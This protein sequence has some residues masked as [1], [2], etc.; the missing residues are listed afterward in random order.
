MAILLAFCSFKNVRL[1]VSKRPAGKTGGAFLLAAAY[2]GTNYATL[3]VDRPTLAVPSALQSLALNILL[4][5]G[6][7]NSLF[8]RGIWDRFNH[9]FP[10]KMTFIVEGPSG[11]TAFPN[12]HPP[13]ITV[14]RNCEPKC[15]RGRDDYSAQ[16]S[17]GKYVYRL[18][19]FLHSLYTTS[20]L[21]TIPTLNSALVVRRD[22]RL[23][24]L[25]VESPIIR[26]D[27]CVSKR[28]DVSP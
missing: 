23:M 27:F 14:S 22:F 4:R 9:P 15:D 20:D 16:H 19:S 1:L 6:Y 18:I 24:E 26:Q 2:Q 28:R 8:G 3:A 12:L 5:C 7:G 10:A 25:F 21:A 17:N 11:A 13:I